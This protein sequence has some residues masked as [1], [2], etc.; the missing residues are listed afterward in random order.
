MRVLLLVSSFNGLSRRAWC[1][2][3]E[4]GHEVGVLLAT[5]EQ[6]IVDGVLTAAPDL[7]LCPYLTA[8]VPEQVW[9]TVPTV[10]IRPGPVG[11]HGPSPLDWAIAGGAETWGVTALEAVAELGAGPVWAT[12]TFPMPAA[13][14]RKS[15]LYNGPVADAAMECIFE[16]VHKA[17]DPSFVPAPPIASASPCRA[18]GGDPP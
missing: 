17:A 1:A 6:D 7:V 2:L 13:A 18:P 3:R 11:D 9:R 5:G 14:P 16:V 10:V 15:A 4:A 8:R 12:R